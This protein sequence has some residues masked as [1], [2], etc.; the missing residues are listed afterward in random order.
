MKGGDKMKKK[1]LYLIFLL[2]G[3]IF[4]PFA[5]ILLFSNYQTKKSDQI[6]N[7]VK[8]NLLQDG[9][10][11]TGTWIHVYP[12]TRYKSD[13]PITYT[14][15]FSTSDSRFSFTCLESGEIIELHELF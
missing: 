7:K 12:K 1:Y 3:I 11:F 13:L 10:A 2:G 14:G 15:G 5:F 9:Y 4:L 6:L 8:N